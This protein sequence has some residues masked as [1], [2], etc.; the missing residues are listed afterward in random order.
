[1]GTGAR[2]LLGDV[3][4]PWISRVLTSLTSTM[5]VYTF[6]QQTP[7]PSM[8]EI[9]RKQF[10]VRK[11]E[12]QTKKKKQKKSVR[13][14]CPRSRFFT[15]ACAC[16]NIYSINHFMVYLIGYFGFTCGI[17]FRGS[18]RYTWLRTAAN[19]TSLNIKSSTR[20]GWSGLVITYNYVYILK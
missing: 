5:H 9:L 13:E 16:V 17:P 10:Q 18:E 4:S 8:G 12:N 20:M 2:A 15:F 14:S 3:G 7:K 11:R 1:M 6:I 19:S